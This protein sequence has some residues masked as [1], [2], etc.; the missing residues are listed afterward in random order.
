[1][2]AVRSIDW[3]AR[4]AVRAVG[5]DDS[6]SVGTA[7]AGEV[8]ELASA[9]LLAVAAAS[10]VDGVLAGAA[11]KIVVHFCVATRVNRSPRTPNA[12]LLRGL[13]AETT[14]T[15]RVDTHCTASTLWQRK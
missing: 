4:A 10:T 6:I 13:T 3:V 15:V 5:F 14:D 11:R 2:A 7:Q 8:A 1:M 12:D 9:A